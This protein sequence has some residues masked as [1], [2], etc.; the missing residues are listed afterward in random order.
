MKYRVFASFETASM[1]EAEI[2]AAMDFAGS[3][4]HWAD[5]VALT[6]GRW[7]FASP[8]DTGEVLVAADFPS[9]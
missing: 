9:D 4:T 5:I 6:G 8:D 2:S 3:T 7:A 1:A